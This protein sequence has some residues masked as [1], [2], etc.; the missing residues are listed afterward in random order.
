MKV[1]Q[2]TIVIRPCNFQIIWIKMEPTGMFIADTSFEYIKQMIEI[3]FAD[4]ATTRESS[5][6]L[7]KMFAQRFK[8]V[9]KIPN[10]EYFSFRIGW[11]RKRMCV[12]F[13]FFV[14]RNS[15]IIGKSSIS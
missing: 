8:Q 14:E 1:L 12:M 6:T 5:Y 10:P 3:H 11:V 4:F 2:E 7:K 9:H 13:V 15:N